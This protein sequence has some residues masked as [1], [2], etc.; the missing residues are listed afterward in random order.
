[1]PLPSERAPFSP[2]FDDFIG[3]ACVNKPKERLTTKELL[4]HPF[5][6]NSVYDDEKNDTSINEVN[7]TKKLKKQSIIPT[8]IKQEVR[9]QER[10]R[11]LPPNVV[12]KNQE[13]KSITSQKSNELK[14]NEKMDNRS[15]SLS[16]L[17]SNDSKIR[18]NDMDNNNDN[19]NLSPSK[20]PV[21][22][23]A[24]VVHDKNISNSGKKVMF[25]S[26]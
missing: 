20:I 8:K 17:N 10:T 15:N 23:D 1:V 25:T 14:K 16:S 6:L 13:I 11:S 22:I 3:K 24:K 2:V 26:M 9:T 18:N 21:R 12:L 7:L 4:L 5:I 19:E